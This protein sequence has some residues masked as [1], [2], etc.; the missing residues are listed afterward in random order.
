[1]KKIN[2]VGWYATN[3]RGESALFVRDRDQIM[4]Q[5]IARFACE[6]MT[7]GGDFDWRYC[8]WTAVADDGDTR[9]IVEENGNNV[10]CWIYEDMELVSEFTV[11][12]SV[13]PEG[14]A[15]DFEG[16]S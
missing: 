16:E 8:G 12:T 5:T 3:K 11:L 1:M 15:R 6:I 14:G 2:G 4:L 7:P 13:D 9:C 10:S